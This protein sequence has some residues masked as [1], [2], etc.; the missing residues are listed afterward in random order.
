MKMAPS[1]GQGGWSSTSPALRQPLVGWERDTAP[2]GAAEPLRDAEHPPPFSLPCTPAI[3][4]E[5]NDSVCTLLPLSVS[6]Q[7]P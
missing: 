2:W 7:H 4:L 5:G 6:I 1:P 3:F